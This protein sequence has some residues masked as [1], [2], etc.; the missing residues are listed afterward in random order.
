[1]K[2]IVNQISV[3]F[4]PLAKYGE[5]CTGSGCKAFKFIVWFTTPTSLKPIPW[6]SRPQ[7]ID[8]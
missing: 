3:L 4:R 8:P 1:M 5:L 2:P 7:R 6:P